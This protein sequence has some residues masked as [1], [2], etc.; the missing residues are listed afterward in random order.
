MQYKKIRHRRTAVFIFVPPIICSSVYIEAEKIQK[1]EQCKK[2]R[3]DGFHADSLHM[4]V[5]KC[6]KHRFDNFSPVPGVCS[7]LPFI[8]LR[9]L[10]L[11]LIK[12][13]FF[14]K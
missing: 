7:F 13:C 12:E 11:L 5:P 10:L 8:F 3:E 2:N 4:T 1:K 9:L 6:R 14:A